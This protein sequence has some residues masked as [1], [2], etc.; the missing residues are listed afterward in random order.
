MQIAIKAQ[1]HRVL[2]GGSSVKRRRPVADGPD[3]K[4]LGEPQLTAAMKQHAPA[5]W[6]KPPSQRL[7]P[8]LTKFVA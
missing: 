8:S 3:A 2:A 6:M 5:P 4:R 1:V 7:A